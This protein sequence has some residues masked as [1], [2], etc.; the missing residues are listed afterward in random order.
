MTALGET[1][2]VVVDDQ[3]EH[4][5][6]VVRALSHEGL[7]VA[8]FTGA[9]E[10]LPPKALSGVRLAVLDMDLSEGDVAG[11]EPEARL[12][13]LLA[14]LEKL[15]ARTNGPYVAVIWTSYPEMVDQFKA[16]FAR[17]N[18]TAP[19]MVIAQLSK[20][21]FYAGAELDAGRLRARLLESLEQAWPLSLLM[22][23]ES[24]SR[25]ASNDVVSVFSETTLAGDGSGSTAPGT[26]D[27]RME[28]WNRRVAAILRALTVA[29]SDEA[30]SGDR[31]VIAVYA[32]LNEIQRDQLEKLANRAEAETKRR[33]ERLFADGV[34]LHTRED[35]ALVNGALMFS[36]PPSTDPVPWPGDVFLFSEV[37]TAAERVPIQVAS[38]DIIKDVM[39]RDQLAL[40]EGGSRTLWHFVPAV[41]A[42]CPLLMVEVTPVCDYVQGKRRCASF[43]C[44]LLVP[45]QHEGKLKSNLPHSVWRSP[46]FTISDVPRA[47][48]RDVRLVLDYHYTLSIDDRT[49][50]DSQPLFRVR[51]GVLVDIQ[52]GHGRHVSRPGFTSVDLPRPP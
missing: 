27:Q 24:D 21:E 15:I 47:P 44:G 37:F 29:M 3:P 7:G 30:V 52:A 20:A 2:I 13:P 34:P 48:T 45:N 31:A 46:P 18:P 16:E 50:R 17:R 33:C 36:R 26:L 1:S 49:L 28:L 38:Q 32:G 6:P 39:D 12:A 40:S 8:Y 19:P 11:R 22:G 35:T 41:S 10:E 9:I 4:G 25:K 14:V 51:E 43:V 5:I 42:D 23:W